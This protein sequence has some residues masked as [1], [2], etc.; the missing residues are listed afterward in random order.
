MNIVGGDAIIKAQCQVRGGK[1]PNIITLQKS[2]GTVG[3]QACGFLQHT[4]QEGMKQNSLSKCRRYFQKR[5]LR[6]AQE[7]VWCM[8]MESG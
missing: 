6:S 2:D 8:Q 4:T 3:M 7:Y 1:L 5:T